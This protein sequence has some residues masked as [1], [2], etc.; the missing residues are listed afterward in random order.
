MPQ[1]K[2]E[3]SSSTA[4]SRAAADGTATRT[5][6]AAGE[7]AAKSLEPARV[8][9]HLETAGVRSRSAT[10]L[11]LSSTLPE[12][13]ARTPTCTPTND[14]DNHIEVA[15][16]VR[17]TP[18]DARLTPHNSALLRR[19]WRA[20]LGRRAPQTL[21]QA[22]MDRILTW[23]EQAAEVGDISLRSRAIL[24]AALAGNRSAVRSPGCAQNGASGQDPDARRPLLHAPVRVGT[25]FVRE[26]TGVLQRVVVGADGFEWEGRTYASLSAVARAITGVRWNGRRFFA[27]GRGEKRKATRSAAGNDKGMPGQDVTQRLGPQRVRTGPNRAP[28]AGGDP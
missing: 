13:Q 17:E 5:V 19:R 22:L 15:A 12:R 2:L 16:E 3:R 14:P 25:V 4:P 20:L 8:E 10:S 6:A 11:P 7:E 27:L 23:R 28:G 1:R 9:V 26:H 18:E 24:A 21:S